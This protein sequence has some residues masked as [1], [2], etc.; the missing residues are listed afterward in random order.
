MVT[1]DPDDIV[2]DG[3]LLEKII[4]ERKQNFGVYAS[5]VEPG[6]VRNGDMVYLD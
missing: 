1:L 4:N 2:K 6:R 3:T 5:I